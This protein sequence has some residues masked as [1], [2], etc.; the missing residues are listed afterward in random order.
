MG[1]QGERLP[2]P[3]IPLQQAGTPHPLGPD[4]SGMEEEHDLE[5]RSLSSPPRGQRM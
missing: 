4:I 1:G 3:P 5:D 2:L